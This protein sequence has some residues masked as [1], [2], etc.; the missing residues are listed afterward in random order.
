MVKFR[1]TQL[2]IIISV[3][4]CYI[5]VKFSYKKADPSGGRQKM[6]H[7]RPSLCGFC[8]AEQSVVCFNCL[9]VQVVWS[10][11]NKCYVVVEVVT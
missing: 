8:C 11:S 3:R 10:M 9:S 2:Q 1:S 4:A 5:D 6:T 7:F